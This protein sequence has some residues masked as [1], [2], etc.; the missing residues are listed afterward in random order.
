MLSRVSIPVS[1]RSPKK[2]P[3]R[4]KTHSLNNSTLKD[5]PLRRTLFRFHYYSVFHYSAW[6]SFFYGNSSVSSMPYIQFLFVRPRFCLRLLSDSASRRT[7]LS[8][9]N[10]SYCQACSGLSPPSGYACRAHIKISPEGVPRLF[11]KCRIF[12][13]QIQQNAS[14]NLSVSLYSLNLRKR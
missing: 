12:H 14:K 7:P 6:T 1:E 13:A 11:F 5:S 8:L 10:S 2:V 9:A 3:S 4:T